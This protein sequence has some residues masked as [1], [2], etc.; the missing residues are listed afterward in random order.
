MI[1]LDNEKVAKRWK[2]YIEEPYYG[3]DVEKNVYIE[4]DVDINNRGPYI[5]IDEFK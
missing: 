1:L 2:K 5:L 3:E 4:K